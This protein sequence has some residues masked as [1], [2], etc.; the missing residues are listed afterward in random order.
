MG[1]ERAEEADLIAEA[2]EN[3]IALIL[4]EFLGH[5]PI[6]R[7][8]ERAEVRDGVKFLTTSSGVHGNLA[9]ESGTKT[10][11]VCGAAPTVAPK[12]TNQG[13]PNYTPYIVGAVLLIGMFYYT[14]Y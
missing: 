4:M 7:A 11:D 9:F 10:S 1:G 8:I 13:T 14:R 6:V 12:G 5:G 3:L 2:H